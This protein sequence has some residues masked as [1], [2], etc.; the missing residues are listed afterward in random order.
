MRTNEPKD[1]LDDSEKLWRAVEAIHRASLHQHNTNSA[2]EMA[3]QL[4]GELLDNS[5][6]YTRQH[7]QLEHYSGEHD[8]RKAFVSWLGRT[9]TFRP[10]EIKQLT[11]VGLLRKDSEGQLYLRKQGWDS[12]LVAVLFT[13]IGVFAGLWGGWIIF[14]GKGGLHDIINSLV[15]GYVLGCITSL[16]LNNSIR[17]EHYRKKVI[18]VA[19]WLVNSST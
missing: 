9:G 4:R 1:S 17:L 8:V 16:V 11:R 6:S 13:L 15:F 7:A 3:D 5:H 2:N 18:S 14:A 12:R 19:P 10:A